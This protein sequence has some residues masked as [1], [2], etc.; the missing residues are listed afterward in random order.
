MTSLLLNTAANSFSPDGMM[1][2]PVGEI[3]LFIF[4]KPYLHREQVLYFETIFPHFTTHCL[5]R[6][7]R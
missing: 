5:P 2:C 6:K 1:T 7:A 3:H 4:F